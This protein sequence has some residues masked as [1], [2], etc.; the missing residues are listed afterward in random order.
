MRVAADAAGFAELVR[1]GITVFL[2]AVHCFLELVGLDRGSTGVAD[3]G[4][5]RIGL[6]VSGQR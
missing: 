4:G 3:D 1:S 5:P 2:V 6:D